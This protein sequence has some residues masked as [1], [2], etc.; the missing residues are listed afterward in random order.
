MAAGR[1]DWELPL[2]AKLED[3]VPIK[4][5]FDPQ[6]EDPRVDAAW[7]LFLIV[8]GEDEDA[9]AVIVSGEGK[10]RR[11][12]EE[13]RGK[14][15]RKGRRVGGG[16]GTLQKGPARGIALSVLIK[17]EKVLDSPPRVEPP[18]IETLTWCANFKFV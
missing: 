15:P 9:D 6:D 13:W 12:G 10:W 18:S 5:P 8:Q 16:M 7:V 2:P 4:G 1:F 11:G 3:P 17:P 14:A